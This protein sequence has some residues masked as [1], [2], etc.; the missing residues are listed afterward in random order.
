MPRPVLAL[1]VSLAVPAAAQADVVAVASG[2]NAGTARPPS[3]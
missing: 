3:S 1:I 2:S